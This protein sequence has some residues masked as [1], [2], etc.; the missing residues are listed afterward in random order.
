MTNTGRKVLFRARFICALTHPITILAIICLLANDLIL[1]SYWPDAWWTGKFSDLAWVIFAPPLIGLLLSY[2]LGRNPAAE[3]ASFGTAY[4]LFPLTYA[5]FN[6]IPALH[7]FI[8]G[9]FTLAM[10]GSIGSPRD[11]TDSIVI[12]IGLGVAF[13][14]WSR[15]PVNREN[16]NRSALPVIAALAAL[17]TIATS[18]PP[19][20]PGVTQI[21]AYSDG[22]IF[23]V[24]GG[25]S[26]RIPVYSRDGG[27]T[28]DGTAPP[29]SGTTVTRG[30]E[31]AVGPNGT[32]K[33]E[34]SD[35]VLISGDEQVSLY[36]TRYL[37]SPGNRWMQERSTEEH[38]GGRFLALSP[39][40]LVYDAK[41]GNLVATLGIQGVLVG[42]PE[43]KWERVRVAQFRPTDFSFIA[44]SSKLVSTVSFWNLCLTLTLSTIG[45]SLLAA[46]HSRVRKGGN[47][48]ASPESRTCGPP[49]WTTALVG[50]PCLLATGLVLLFYDGLGSEGYFFY[51]G[52]QVLGSGVA[53][54]SACLLFLKYLEQFRYWRNIGLAFLSMNGFAILSLM[55]WLHLGLILVIA[56]LSALILVVIV[57]E[58]L[59]RYLLARDATQG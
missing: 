45:L 11:P 14:V 37:R 47:G 40:E 2:I 12:P 15:E 30:G 53:Y 38:G 51:L 55:W 43:G 7:E 3:T 28:W 49:T 35:I 39:G 42:T 46:D 10:D 8:I 24:P 32:Y 21:G 48:F 18:G 17:A 23:A 26:L 22:T 36:S 41:S 1:K 19:L 54:V 9:L 16:L 13:W 31:S 50:Y 56:K 29:P 44:K 20:I 59:R 25:D 58:V 27:L 52:L 34:G 4:V 6:T 33:I 57:G 5:A